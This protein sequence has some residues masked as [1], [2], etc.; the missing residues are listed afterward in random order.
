ME[1]MLSQHE[2][3]LN[4]AYTIF[5]KQG[6]SAVTVENISK[7]SKISA[8]EIIAEFS[9]IKNLKENVI[10]KAII[11]IQAL[12]FTKAPYSSFVD[13]DTVFVNLA[14]NRPGW[15]KT[16]LNQKIEHNDFLEQLVDITAVYLPFTKNK[17]LEK[18]WMATAKLLVDVNFDKAELMH[19][20][21]M[22]LA[23]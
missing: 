20:K 22:L 7:Q 14:I 19:A 15:I 3:I 21:A 23:A 8:N 13:L 18:D 4:T 10:S 6:I 2:Q 11:E 12:L 1:N 9:S 16:I 5:N 17:A